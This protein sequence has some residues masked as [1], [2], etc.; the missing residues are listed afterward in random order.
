M[1]VV[2]GDFVIFCFVIIIKNC[3]L[4]YYNNFFVFINYYYRLVIVYVFVI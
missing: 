3:F 1:V 4:E 2:F